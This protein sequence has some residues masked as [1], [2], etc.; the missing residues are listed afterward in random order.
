MPP[1]PSSV[2]STK[3]FLMTEPGCSGPRCPSSACQRPDQPVVHHLRA[4]TPRPQP[5]SVAAYASALAS[6]LQR[7]R[8]SF[9]RLAARCATVASG[10]CWRRLAGRLDCAACVSTRGRTFECCARVRRRGACRRR[11]QP[12]LASSGPRR[13]RGVESASHGAT[14]SRCGAHVSAHRER[15]LIVASTTT[16]V[17]LSRAPP[18]SVASISACADCMGVAF[19]QQ[20]SDPFVVQLARQSVGTQQ[21]A[22]AEPHA[23]AAHIEQQ[24]VF[25]ADRARDRVIRFFVRLSAEFSSAAQV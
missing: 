5:G 21:I 10:S 17:T 1:L 9:L 2:S 18:A 3:R 7:P 22:I 20:R 16:T 6:A 25:A 23:I 24:R 4:C 13:L 14:A 12:G 19:A 11:S 15:R 8:R